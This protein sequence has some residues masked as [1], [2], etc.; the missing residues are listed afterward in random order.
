MTRT[1]RIDGV[2]LLLTVWVFTVLLSLLPFRT[3]LVCLCLGCDGRRW[4]A[5][6]GREEVGHRN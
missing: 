1:A 6:R 3:L 2:S 5:G 4:N